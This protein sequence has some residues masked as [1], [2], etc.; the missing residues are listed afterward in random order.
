MTGRVLVVDDILANVK[1]LEARLSAEYFDVLTA[2]S[3]PEALEILQIERVDVVLL[4]VMMPGLDGFE[5]CRRI[6]ASPKTMH[7][8][9]VMVTALDQTTDKVQGLEAGADDFLTKPVDDIALITR[10]K[11]L[12]R[13]KMLNDEMLLRMATGAEIGVM[14]GGIPA[15]S[16]ADAAGRVLLVEDQERV[17]GRVQAVLA[18]SYEIDIER[19]PHAALL[20]LGSATYDVVIVSLNL[21]EADGLRLCSQLRALERT[22]NQP[23][24]VVLQPDEEVRL[25]RALDMGVNDYLVRPV[26]RNELLAR[27]R[28]QI[29]RKRYSDHLR[30]RLEESVELALTDALTGLNNR[31]YLETHL[32]ALAEQA[33]AADRPLSV[34]FADVDSFKAI[35]DTYGHDAGDAVLRELASRLRRNTRNIDLACRIGGEEFVVVMPDVGLDRASQAAERLRA[36]IAGEPFQVDGETCLQVTASVGI[37][38]LDGVHDSAEG[39]LRRADQALYL[40][41]RGGRNRVVTDAA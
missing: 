4:D 21:A 38:T 16:N 15:L 40:A 17:A 28:T 11:N 14:P 27:V 5:V 23:I 10:V 25:L 37:A 30:D 39:L 36:C 9:V 18:K 8:P 31:R 13:L 22:R 35:N 32:K 33:R 34:L 24:I 12:T 29:K 19:D 26:D 7:V 1:L 41:K 3:G 20:R 6:K 2:Y